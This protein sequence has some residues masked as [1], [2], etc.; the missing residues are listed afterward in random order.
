[1]A[2]A[3]LSAL[4]AKEATVGDPFS[5]LFYEYIAAGATDADK[6]RGVT[7]NQMFVETFRKYAWFMDDLVA[8]NW[9]AQ[10]SS[11]SGG[12]NQSNASETNHPGVWEHYTG[13]DTTGAGGITSGNAYALRHGGGRIKYVTWIK[14]PSALSDG[15]NRY[16]IVA[17][18]S[19][20]TLTYA[21][22]EFC[23]ARYVDNVNSGNWQAT[24]RNGGAESV[25]D[26][27]VAVVADTW[28]RIEIDVNAG[29]TSV[30]VTVNGT[31]AAAVASNVPTAE[32]YF[33]T[34]IIKSAGTT[35]RSMYT[36][37]YG[38]MQHFTTG[39]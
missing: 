11:G 31:A 25:Q 5:D 35:A 37:A 29:A 23:G 4:T 18:Y 3:K 7:P 32:G 26:T 39:R 15:T 22:N 30:V 6:Q 16:S 2:D 1:M 19:R 20:S 34:G 13:T 27:G 12:N 9:I 24:C 21:P 14:T 17:G 8:A 10:Y 33:H 36:D 28:Y 38:W